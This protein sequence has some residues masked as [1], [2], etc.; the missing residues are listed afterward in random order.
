VEVKTDGKIKVVTINRQ[1]ER[2]A[3]NSDVLRAL[4]SIL[5]KSSLSDE[6]QAII[7]TG[8]GNRVF[9][10]GAD[11]AEIQTSSVARINE[12]IEL[13]QHVTSLLEK[14]PFATIAAINGLALGGGL[15]MALACDIR[16]CT[17]ES[18]F[19]L[20]EPTLGVIPAWGGTYRLPRII[21]TG[22]AI[23][24]MLSGGDID[25][26]TAKEFSLVNSV[27]PVDRLMEEAK[28]VAKTITKNPS[29]TTEWIKIAV[30]EGLDSQKKALIIELTG[31]TACYKTPESQKR[32][33]EFLR[34][35]RKI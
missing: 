5:L 2:N 33:S 24:M 13:G 21:G 17:D 34:R 29:A 31:F 16:L 28:K 23:Q 14:A 35:S 20:P 1:Q 9:S 3:I 19:G 12:L 26:Q 4:Q 6:C 8:A 10:A 25:A 15:E 7:L 27:Y 11:I 22:R 30:S 18:K 32:I